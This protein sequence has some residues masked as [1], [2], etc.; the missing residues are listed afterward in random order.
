MF[1]PVR[2]AWQGWAWE[3]KRG[4]SWT[5]WTRTRVGTLGMRPR[6]STPLIR[7][8][9]GWA[10]LPA[11]LGWLLQAVQQ[12]RWPCQAARQQRRSLR[13]RRRRRQS[14]PR[15]ACWAAWRACPA[16]GCLR[17]PPVLRRPR[18]CAACR[19]P[20]EPPVAAARLEAREE[21]ER[22]RR[23]PA[24]PASSTASSGRLAAVHTGT[25]LTRRALA[26]LVVAA[27]ARAISSVGAAAGAA[28]RRGPRAC[29]RCLIPEPAPAATLPPCRGCLFWT[30][31]PSRT[32]SARRAPCTSTS[33]P[34]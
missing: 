29:P 10:F 8:C 19:C 28:A 33:H 12:Q 24:A 15:A 14:R 18:T 1:S 34:A 7:R 27:A 9:S 32:P 21:A 31:P 20:A 2:P 16:W 11:A 13:R 6:G 26:A 23:A 3:G 17:C 4:A 22:A 25:A 30:R 5:W